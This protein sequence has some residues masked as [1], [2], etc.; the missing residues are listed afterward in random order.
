MEDLLSVMKVSKIPYELLAFNP[1]RF[2]QGIKKKK[3]F[4]T[5]LSW[6]MLPFFK[7]KSNEIYINM[8]NLLKKYTWTIPSIFK[9]YLFYE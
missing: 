5:L 1:H 6:P 2:S 8:K 3:E 4:K 7:T 9:Y